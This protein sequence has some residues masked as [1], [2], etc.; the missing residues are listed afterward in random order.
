MCSAKEGVNPS[1]LLKR[2]LGQR[3]MRHRR[4]PFI[5]SSG[6]NCVELEKVNFS[7]FPRFSKYKT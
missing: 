7:Y 3:K 4:A 5:A 2:N 1:K 6:N